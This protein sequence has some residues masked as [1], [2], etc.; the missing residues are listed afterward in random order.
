MTSSS[1]EAAAWQFVAF[2]SILYVKYVCVFSIEMKSGS[3]LCVRTGLF[4]FILFRLGTSD[5]DSGDIY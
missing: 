2:S 5:R 3:V 4:Y 1:T